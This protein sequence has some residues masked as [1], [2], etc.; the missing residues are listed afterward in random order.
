M[1]KIEQ[2]SLRA[3]QHQ[4]EICGRAAPTEKNPVPKIFKMKLFAKN[5]VLA[6]S[7]FWYF[8]KKINKAKK[9]GGEILRQVELFDQKPTT[10]QN[11]GI[12]L[13]YNS[14]TDTHNMYKEYRDVTINGAMSQMIAEMS[15]RHHQRC[16][17]PNDR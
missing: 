7:K 16:Y 9:S 6:R 13:R 3:G 11:Y 14:R 8:M 5:A 10:V 12:W 15:G 4:Y 2:N 1:G 17:V